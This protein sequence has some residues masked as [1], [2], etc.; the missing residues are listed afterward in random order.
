MRELGY[1]EIGSERCLFAFFPH[2]TNTNIR[3]LDH[4]DVVSAVPDA[5]HSFLG[6][7]ANEARNICLL[8]RRTS[9]GDYR[10][11]FRGNLDKLI[12]E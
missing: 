9:T 10:R 4:A 2:N 5:A 11:K 1:G 7:G 8:C 12:L 3:S 6:K